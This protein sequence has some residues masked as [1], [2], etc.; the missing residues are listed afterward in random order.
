MGL[1]VFFDFA[2]VKCKFLKESENIFQ[3]HSSLDL[4]QK[5]RARKKSSKPV[6]IGAL[7]YSGI[8]QARGEMFLSF[9]HMVKQIY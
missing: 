7:S 3:Q 4:L 5:Q 8:G 1:R 6:R 9:I 2:S